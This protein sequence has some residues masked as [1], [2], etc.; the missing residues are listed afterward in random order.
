T[1]ES[2]FP[3]QFVN[4]ELLLNTVHGATLI[5]QAGVQRGAPGTY[6]YVVDADQ[7]VSVRKVTLGPGDAA[8][9]SITQGLAAGETVVVD[10]ADKL[11]DGARILLRGNSGGR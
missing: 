7:T 11:K 2:L 3:Q 6:V 9:V 4:V 10:G 8:N 5:P 1:D